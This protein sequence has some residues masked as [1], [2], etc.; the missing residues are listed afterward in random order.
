M[1]GCRT[2]APGTSC[3]ASRQ[4]R[5]I[6]SCPSIICQSIAAGSFGLTRNMVTSCVDPSTGRCPAL[7]T[8][9]VDLRSARSFPKGVHG[10]PLVHFQRSSGATPPYRAARFVECIGS[11]RWRKVTYST[12]I[13]V[14]ALNKVKFD[15][16]ERANHRHR[17][18]SPRIIRTNTLHDSESESTRICRTRVY[19]IN[20]IGTIRIPSLV[21]DTSWHARGHSTACRVHTGT[22]HPSALVWNKVVVPYVVCVLRRA[23]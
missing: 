7:S 2:F 11:Y 19:I 14:Q 8:L 12:L 5:Q 3:Q 15:I 16:F 9:Y 17:I 6:L 1:D 10:T 13:R 4:R 23:S 18:L 20:P 22:F 21:R